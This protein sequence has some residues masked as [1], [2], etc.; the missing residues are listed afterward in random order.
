MKA[1][2]ISA[3]PQ[4]QTGIVVDE[5]DVNLSREIDRAAS[6]AGMWRIAGPTSS[7]S[8][9]RDV[10]SITADHMKH[11]GVFRKVTA[12]RSADADEYP[13][14]LR[15][16]ISAFQAGGVVQLDAEKK[17]AAGTIGGTPGSAIAGI[18]T[19]N[20]KTPV[21][22]IVELRE[23]SLTDRRTGKTLWHAPSISMST[24]LDGAHYLQAD[25][26]ILQRRLAWELKRVNTELIR[27]LA[28]S[29]GD[30]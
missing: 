15:G 4:I 24:D 21:R 6:E 7:Q 22:S 28:D 17:F 10:S 5:F 27:Q 3:S 11:S 18:A 20:V 23:V 13:L 9:G 29:L 12:D 19:R 1:D 8:L 26:D 14:I 2:R 16:T 25:R 30:E